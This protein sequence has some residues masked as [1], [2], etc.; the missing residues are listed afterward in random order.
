MSH[1]AESQPGRQV[2]P[3]VPTGGVWVVLVQL[4]LL[5][6]L[7][8]L[9]QVEQQRHFFPLL[10][11]LIGGFA[12]HACLPA[13]RRMGWFACLS[14]ASVFYILGAVPAAWVLAIVGC[15]I[16]IARL[17]VR[18]AIRASLL[19]AGM[20]A[21]TVCRARFPAPF[22]P[23]LGSM[24]MFRLLVYLGETRQRTSPDSL[25]ATAAYLFMTPNVSFPL[26]PVVDY[27]TFCGAWRAGNDPA[28]QQRGVNWILRGV[29]HLLLYRYIKAYLVPLPHELYDLPHIALFMAT[30]YALYLQ[31]SGQFHLITGL[32]HLFGFDL[33]RTHHNYFLASSFSDIWRRI[34][35]YWKDFLSK[36]CFFPVLYLL[37]GRGASLNVAVVTGVFAVFVA[38]WLLH[39]WQT[40]WLLGRFPVTA[41]DAALW[42]GAGACVAVNALWET[43]RGGRRSRTAW[44][45]VREAAQ[46][47]GMFGLVSLFWAIWTRPGFHLIVLGVWQRP[48][49]LRG[50]A[51][52]AGWAAA[53]A[54]GVL[55]WNMWEQR[56]TARTA[57]RPVLSL[58]DHARLQAVA[59][60]LLLAISLPR[61]SSLL[62]PRWSQALADFRTDAASRQAVAADRLQGYYEDLNT[63]A[64]QAGPLV[65]SFSPADESRRRLARGFDKI[66]RK[67]DLYQELELIPDLATDLDGTQFTTN[68]Y[69]MRDRRG[70]SLFK[71][72][73][74]IRIALLGSSIVMGYGVTDDEVF[75]RVFEKQL[76]ASRPAG[77]PHV[78]VL[79]F[80]MGKQWATHRLVRAQRMIF[81]FD[82]DV[83]MYVAHQDEVA[84]IEQHNARLLWNGLPLPS[85]HMQAVA[86]AA[87]ISADMPE[88]AIASQLQSHRVEMLQAVYQT[89][90]EE[91]R[92]RGVLPVY[93][94]MPIPGSVEEDPGPQFLS[95]AER[96]GFVTCDLTGWATGAKLADLFPPDDTEHPTP[97]GH[98][99][100]AQA[101]LQLV[102]QRPEL[103][104]APSP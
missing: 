79:N 97:L 26:F 103:I 60:A 76:N 20:L 77:A 25:A 6:A 36:F 78:E 10:C 101:L 24:L 75:G 49:A 31:V 27:Q 5:A 88:G 55:F 33:P 39:S 35:I 69:G 32:L 44:T 89:F 40:F 17:P 48:D 63:A 50:A 84:T 104:A 90:V 83:L 99:L 23:V 22:W 29:V 9:Y 59:L 70:L 12:V 46:T 2:A 80:G 102:K 65:A 85:P 54:L 87:G 86:D 93:V 100:I 13:T 74:T 72:R 38:T 52:V 47:V 21:L 81:G 82:P 92:S 42:L 16:G 8:R 4:G 73:D 28:V 62:G 96:A 53:A 11:L 57:G 43:R 14:I 61:F 19:A 56:W 3:P 18:F 34:N 71:P 30:N 98:R 64:I 68:E 67:A 94:Y 45:A 37:R 7:V 51:V 91:C 15:V 58:R 66:A 41:N 1:T 95:L